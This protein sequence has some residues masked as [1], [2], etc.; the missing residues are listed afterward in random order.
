MPYYHCEKCH[1]E[2]E[3]IGDEKPKC[4]WCGADAYIL[5][6]K[7]P[8]ERMGDMLDDGGFYEIAEKRGWLL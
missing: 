8:L 1:H 4:G 7:T 6:E 3:N 2:F 5:E